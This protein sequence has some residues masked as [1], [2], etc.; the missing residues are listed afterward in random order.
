M[1]ATFR[2]TGTFDIPSR[3]FFSVVGHIETGVVR[4]GMKTK[5]PVHQSSTSA[6]PIDGV[7]KRRR[8]GVA[9]RFSSR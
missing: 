2:V 1:P 9:L 4:L 8:K 3:R 5:L 7:D 6:V